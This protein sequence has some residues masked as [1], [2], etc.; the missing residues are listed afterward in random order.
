MNIDPAIQH[1]MLVGVKDNLGK[2]YD[3]NQICG[4]LVRLWHVHQ[5]TSVFMAY[6]YQLFLHGCNAQVV[7]Y[8]VVLVQGLCFQVII[9]SF[10]DLLLFQFSYS[11][12]VLHNFLL[13]TVSITKTLKPLL[14]GIIVISENRL[15][16]LQYSYGFFW[17]VLVYS[18]QLSKKCQFWLTKRMY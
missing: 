5:C 13:V 2:N 15:F 4:V 6:N 1:V 10:L 18:S 7:L 3:R 9:V 12:P 11:F 14:K 8:N 17:Y 16:L